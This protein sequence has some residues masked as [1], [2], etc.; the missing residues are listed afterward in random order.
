MSKV[1][2]DRWPLSKLLTFI[3]KAGLEDWAGFEVETLLLELGVEPGELAVDKLGLARAVRTRPELFYDDVLFFLHATEVM[4]NQVAD[5]F[6]VPFPTSLELAFS[7]FDMGK[8]VDKASEFSVGVKK[9]IQYILAEEGYHASISPFPSVDLVAGTEPNDMKDKETAIKM[10]VL[11][12]Y[13]E[14][15]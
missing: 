2:I 5:F 8:C 3:D 11:S 7:I 1:I 15:A 13:Q 10:Y 14:K 9:V 6:S 4:N 12:M